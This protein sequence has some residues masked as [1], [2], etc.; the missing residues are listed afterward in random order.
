MNMAPDIES[1]YAVEV[2]RQKSKGID[3]E[4]PGLS[5]RGFLERY[6]HIPKIGEMYEVTLKLDKA[7]EVFVKAKSDY[8][9]AHSLFL[10]TINS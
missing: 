1:G 9:E 3:K 2:A 6:N 8:S 4:F 10:K 5:F 7:R